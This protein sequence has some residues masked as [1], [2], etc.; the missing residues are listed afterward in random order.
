MDVVTEASRWLEGYGLANASLAL[1]VDALTQVPGGKGYRLPGGYDRYALIRL[2][3]N[4]ERTL[5]FLNPF[6]PP[7]VRHVLVELNSE[8]TLC[9]NNSLPN[10]S[11]ADDGPSLAQ[12]TESR[13]FRVVNNPNQIWKSDKLKIVMN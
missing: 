6:T 10:S 13:V 7:V 2:E 11:F 1:C 9:L 3:T 8:W 5:S 4:S 12:R